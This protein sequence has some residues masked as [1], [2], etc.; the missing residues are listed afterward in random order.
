M[1]L[2]VLLLGKRN[3]SAVSHRAWVAFMRA[4]LAR[5]P[6]R[7]Y[8]YPLVLRASAMDVSYKGLRVAP[9]PLQRNGRLGDWRRC[10]LGG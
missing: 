6:P 7:P 5:R 1:S 9:G 2:W 3:T 4:H 10:G 8:P